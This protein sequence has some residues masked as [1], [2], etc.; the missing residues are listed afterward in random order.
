MCI[1][2]IHT[3]SHKTLLFVVIVKASE[4]LHFLH[5]FYLIS[6]I[7]RFHLKPNSDNTS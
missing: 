7:T 1:A 2:L 5:K 4:I 3:P 6:E